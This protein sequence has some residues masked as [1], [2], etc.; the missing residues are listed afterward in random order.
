MGRSRLA[1]AALFLPTRETVF[2]FGEALRLEEIV[3]LRAAISGGLSQKIQKNRMKK[4]VFRKITNRHYINHK[5]RSIVIRINE[6][7]IKP[8]YIYQGKV[9]GITLLTKFAF[10]T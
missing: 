2:F 1:L 10:L 4:P 8:K 3:A 7:L 6:Y 9:L 5:Y